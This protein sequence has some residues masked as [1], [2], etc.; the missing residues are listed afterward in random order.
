VEANTYAAQTLS[1]WADEHADTNETLQTFARK[2]HR[3]F[4]RELAPT[5]AGA[6]AP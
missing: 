6:G 1:R 5:A 3:R 2:L 4:G